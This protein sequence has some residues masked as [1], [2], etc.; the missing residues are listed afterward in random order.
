[1]FNPPPKVRSGVIR[2]KRNDVQSLPC[3]EKHF[4]NVVKTAFSQR[5]KTL[6]NALKPLMAGKEN[7]SVPFLDLRAEQL[8]VADFLELANSLL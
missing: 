6:R 7:A 8:T 4:R 3:D 2:M 1:V 5:R